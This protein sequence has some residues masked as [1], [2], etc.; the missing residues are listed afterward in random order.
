MENHTVSNRRHGYFTYAKVYISA[1]RRVFREEFFPCHFRFIGRSKVGG[2]AYKRRHK[3]FKPVYRRA[4]RN[5]CGLRL[6]ARL[7][8]SLVFEYLLCRISGKLPVPGCFHIRVFFAIAAKQLV[9][10]RFG[11]GLFS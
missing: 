9:P 5:S 11:A 6:V 1:L 2:A 10:L 8:I 7:P 3:V 4:G